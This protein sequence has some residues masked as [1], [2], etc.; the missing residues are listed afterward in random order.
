MNNQNDEKY[1]TPK[2]LC[3][4]F[5]FSDWFMRKCLKQGIPYLK[6]GRDYRFR[7]LEVENWLKEQEKK[8]G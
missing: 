8:N 6:I 5:A 4:H 1:V 7:I 2:E 3:A